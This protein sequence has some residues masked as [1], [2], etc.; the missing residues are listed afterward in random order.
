MNQ[1]RLPRPLCVLLPVMAC[2]LASCEKENNAAPPPPTVTVTPVQERVIQDSVVFTGRTVAVE[3]V[4][5]AEGIR[6]S[7]KYLSKS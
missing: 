5:V 1:L 7:L 3:T 4:A 6:Q 2:L